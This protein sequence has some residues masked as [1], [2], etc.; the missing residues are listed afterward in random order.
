M[1]LKVF[2]IFFLTAALAAWSVLANSADAAAKNEKECPY[3]VY[4]MLGFHVSFYHSWRGDTPDEAGFGTDIR[5]VRE[6]LKMMNQANASGKKAR[7]YWDADIYWTMENIIPQYA[8]DI[9][10]GIRSRADRGLDEVLP[11][12]YNNGANHAAT[13]DEFRTAVRY[14]LSNPYGSGLRQLFGKVAPIYRPQE[15]MYTTGQNRIFLEEGIQGVILYY[16]TI[17]FDNFAE[18]IPPLPTEQRYNAVWFRSVPDEKPI[19]QLNAISPA[20]VVNFTS[21]EKLM[22]DLH[23]LQVEGKVKSDLLIHINFDADAETWIPMNMPKGL[24]WIPNTGGLVEY[25]DAVNKYDWA[26]FAVPSEYLKKN[27]PQ[28]EI[29]VRQDQADGAF[30]GNYSWAEKFASINNWTMLEKSR[31]H[32]YQ[33]MALAKRVPKNLAD[34]INN[35]LW[36]GTESSFFRR[37]VGLT[38]THFGMSTPIIN[39]ER[40]AKAEAVI[41]SAEKIAADAEK[42]AAAQIKKQSK[43]Q[44]DALYEF[45]VYN[46]ARGKNAAAKAATMIVRVPIILPKGI[47]FVTVRDDSGR[48]AMASLV[49]VKKLH[50]GSQVAEIMM[51]LDMGPEERKIFSVTEPSMEF[52]SGEF[53]RSYK[54]I[55]LPELGFDKNGVSY[56]K[57][58]GHEI[59]GKDFLKPFITYRSDKKL[60]TFFSSGFQ[61]SSP[62]G[63]LLR[64]MGR[65]RLKSEIPMKTSDGI[66]MTS[67]T[68]T[69]TAFN[70]LPY[71]LADIE[72]NYAYTTPR[73]TIHSMQQKLRRLLDLRWIEVAPFQINPAI[74]AKAETPL[75]VWKHNYLDI[76][77]YYD[78]NYG[79]INP[80]NKNLD[81]FNH[82]VTAGWVAMTNGKNG[83]LIAESA[84]A[85][86]SLGFCPMRLREID[87]VQHLSLNPFGSYFG[88]QLDYSNLGG[89]HVGTDIAV[90]ASGSLKPNGPS[91]NGQT[92]KFSL[93]LAPYDGDQPPQKMQNDAAAFFYSFGVVYLKTPDGIDAVV[94]E[95]VKAIIAAKEKEERMMSTAPLA[96]PT[97]FLANPSD[98]SVDLVWDPPRDERVTGYEIHWKL[99][100]DPAWQT[101]KI[102]I[103]NR[104]HLDKMKNDQVYVFQIK[105]LAKGYESD[106]T[107]ESKCAPGPVKKVSLVSSAKGASMKTML[108]VAYYALVH[109][110]STR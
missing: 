72:V 70:D 48:E 108:K 24:G 67:L 36:E 100:K 37:L 45:E 85:L 32:S 59:G 31:I 96:K 77:S 3:Q 82:Q 99:E 43:I 11:G 73:D 38:T 78:L 62:E 64:S 94:P 54:N 35:K 33:A 1:N 49:N 58:N 14:S 98:Q 46:Y 50:D 8:P 68:Y 87:G 84:D 12:P 63:E 39:E 71:L 76:T 42:S 88:N 44:S 22:L 17:A 69:F 5:L 52:P 30:D 56:L 89:N 55:K 28:G 53:S 47:G 34:D 7:A 79:Q 4:V 92:E 51:V 9:I 16:S 80:K 25:I 29:L 86:S 81:S 105:A 27:P 57:Y 19:I 65:T 13:E 74:T 91:Y 2:K 83:L 102:G 21:L 110:L 103:A 107:A 15:G 18:F 90:M 23:K 6:L 66:A 75:R 61:V 93:L 26:D 10:T 20:D 40:Q 106:W 95:D 101:E 41:G 109:V 104:R 97:A 60:E